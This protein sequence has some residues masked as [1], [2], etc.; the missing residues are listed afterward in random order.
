MKIINDIIDIKNIDTNIEYNNEFKQLYK[1]LFF[2]IE[3]TGLSPERDYIF[4]LCYAIIKE[5]NI[6]LTQIMCEC[7]EDEPELLK[8]FS[9]NI[10]DDN[11]FITYNGNSFDIPFIMKRCEKYGINI[12]FNEKIDIYREITRYKSVFLLE[13]YKQK[14]IEKF[15]KIPR[16]DTL[17]GKEMTRLYKKYISEKDNKDESL[18]L[19][20]NY[21]D[22]FNLIK[23]L[24]IKKYLMVFEGKF[25]DI[26]YNTEQY[27]D[28]NGNKAIYFIIKATFKYSV[29]TSV[30][31]NNKSS[32]VKIHNNEVTISTKTYNGE[33]LYFFEDYKNYY[34]LPFEDYAIHKSVASYVD[35][36]YRIQAKA[37]NCYQ[38]VN[39]T[40]IP[41]YNSNEHKKFVKKYNDDK[42]YILL[43]DKTFN[44]SE[45]ICNYV[46]NIFENM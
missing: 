18:L 36:N 6:F 37:A 28:E 14:T 46:K 32:F 35:R 2:D 41:A 21:E 39:G 33:L 17:S 40:F 22:V 23:L 26:T 29:P 3:T 42:E 20:H 1:Y 44:T 27:S 12:S 43:N 30:S 10:C 8:T 5:K 13:N 45:L 9:D 15:L 38:H 34:Y 25:E 11:I 7:A 4:M 16:K 31:F 19:Q 24:D